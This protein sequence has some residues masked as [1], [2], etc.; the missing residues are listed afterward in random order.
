MY[1]Y[2]I[3]C[4]TESCDKV[5]I[6]AREL[7]GCEAISPKQVQHTW[8][9]GRMIDRVHHLLPGY[10]FLYFQEKVRN[11]A[12]FH[13]VSG[14]IRCLCDT[15]K[16]YELTG[17]NERFA[18]MLYHKNG[19]I[20]KTKVYQEG[21]LIRVCRGAFEGLETK[22]LKVDHRCSRMQI[23][24]PFAMRP[25]KTWVEYEIVSPGGQEKENPLP[26]LLSEP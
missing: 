7:F 17:D 4:A 19:I 5:A 10:V 25:V 6:A 14:V 9:K 11:I 18:L 15:S 16:E 22:V 24:I 20:G 26:S 21:Q 8:V 23:E 2:C 12:Q 3:F 1:I 13:M